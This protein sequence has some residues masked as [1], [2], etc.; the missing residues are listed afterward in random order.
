MYLP[1]VSTAPAANFASVVDT[2]DKFATGVND[3]GGKFATGVND[4]GGKLPPVST[5]P[6]ANL[7][8][9]VL[10]TLVANNGNIINQTA[11]NLK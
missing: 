10:T 1:P 5:T 6:A 4:V 8:P 9:V 2:G 7:P 3:T 11:D